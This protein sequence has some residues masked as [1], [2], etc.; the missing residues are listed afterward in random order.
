MSSLWQKA[1]SINREIPVNTQVKKHNS[2]FINASPC[3]QSVILHLKRA[4]YT[5]K[6][7]KSCLPPLIEFPDITEHGWGSNGN[8]IWTTSEFPDSI[9]ELL[10]STEDEIDDDDKF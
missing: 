6:V 7:W 1:T 8:V 5:A 2:R 4:N 3:K 9:V 10:V